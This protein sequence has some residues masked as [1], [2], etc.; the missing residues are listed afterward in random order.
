MLIAP[1]A[2][3]GTGRRFDIAAL[4]KRLD[5]QTGAPAM[6]GGGDGRWLKIVRGALPGAGEWTHQYANE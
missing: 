4:K 3:K 5:K 6:I 2:E 1:E